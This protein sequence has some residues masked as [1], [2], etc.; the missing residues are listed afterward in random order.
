VFEKSGKFR[1][2]LDEAGRGPRGGYYYDASSQILSIR[3][4]THTDTA[5]VYWEGADRMI[6]S[7][8]D[9]HTKTTMVRISD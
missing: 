8:T 9:G 5:L 6:H 4:G 2:E 3:Y 7:T 1:M